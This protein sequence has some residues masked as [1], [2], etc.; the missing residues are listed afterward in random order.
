MTQIA[1]RDKKIAMMTTAVVC[2]VC[3][4][5]AFVIVL[6]TVIIP[7]GKYRDAIALLDA[8]NIVEG[9]EALVALN[10]YKDSAAKVNAAFDKYKAEKLKAATFGERVFFGSYEQD[11][12]TTNGRE[13]IEWLVLTKKDSKV[14]LISDK[15]LDCRPYNTSYVDITWETCSLR[16]WL[17]GAFLNAAFSAEEQAMIADTSVSASKNPKYSTA[18]GNATT[19]KVFLLSINE[20]N[21]YFDSDE[22]SQCVPTAYA[23]TNGAWRRSDTYTAGGFATCLWWLRSPGGNQNRG[24][25]ID[26]AG[27]VSCY[28]YGVNYERGGVRPALWIN[29]D[30]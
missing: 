9:Y 24:A 19:D 15:A 4:I 8:G 20:A 22:A 6:N 13:K 12:N 27:T 11:Y 18:P 17:N 21:R 16:E 14:L 1:K 3:V 10:G 7:N 5:V 28:G 25:V 26:D 30:S 2:V 23:T 29:L